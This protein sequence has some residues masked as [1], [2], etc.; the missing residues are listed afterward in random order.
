MLDRAARSPDPALMNSVVR[1]PADRLS[2]APRRRLLIVLLCLL[3]HPEPM[4]RLQVLQRLVSLPIADPQQMLLP[5][6]VRKLSSLLPDERQ[7]VALA[8]FHTCTARD[9]GLFAEAFAGLLPQRHALVSAVQVLRATVG[10]DRR[11]LVPVARAVLTA[12][13]RD[14]LTAGLRAGLAIE[15]LPW[16]ELA[17]M[18]ERL[19]SAGELHADVLAAC[20]M[21]LGSWAG[22]TDNA[23]LARLEADLSGRSD[24]RLRRLALAALVVQAALPEGWSEARL[25][26]LRAYREDPSPL[27]AAAAQFTL[28]AEE[29]T[30][31]WR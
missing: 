23:D 6:L 31:S 19:A 8:I 13:A 29:E 3:D 2:D 4:V 14:P 25:G 9:A 20:I 24:E 22:R 17:A 15:A 27:V 7:A 5:A 12:L 18:F 28:P 21:A 11:R 1:I 16:Q 26:R 10:G 30:L